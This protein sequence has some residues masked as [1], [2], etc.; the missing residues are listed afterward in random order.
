MNYQ[1]K[2]IENILNEDQIK[3]VKAAGASAI[4]FRRLVEAARNSLRETLAGDHFLLAATN[5]V[6]ETIEDMLSDGMDKESLAADAYLIDILL[7]PE[8]MSEVG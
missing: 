2:A 5:F 8:L 6:D 1:G 7:Q 3:A 4:E